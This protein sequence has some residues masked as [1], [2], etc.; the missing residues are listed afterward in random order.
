Q[1]AAATPEATALVFQD[2]FI[3]YETLNLRANQLAHYLLSEQHVTPE[4]LIGVCSS[5]SVEMVV[6]ILAI[7]KAGGAYVPLDPDYPAS[8]LSYMA[9]D[10]GLKQVIGFGSGLAVAE[11]LMREQAGH[12]IDIATLALDDYPQ[13]NPALDDISSDSLAY[14][15]YTSGSTGQPKGVQL[16]HQGAVNLAHNQQARFGTCADSKV[17]QFA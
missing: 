10:A 5:R 8:R 17:L 11:A 9:A 4:T 3:S 16:I 7:L 6:S 1:Q 14:V 12:A 15:I 2:Q 13:H